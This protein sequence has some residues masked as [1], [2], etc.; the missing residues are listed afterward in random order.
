MAN[1]P[2]CRRCGKECV[3]CADCRGKGYFTNLLGSRDCG[4]CNRTGWLY[5][6]D[7][8]WTWE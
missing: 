1:P 8:K 2:K 3:E 5:R 6:D 7:K 4:G